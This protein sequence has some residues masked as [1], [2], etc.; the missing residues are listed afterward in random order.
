MKKYNDVI[1]NCA[2]WNLNKKYWKVKWKNL[3]KKILVNIKSR[4]LLEYIT[5]ISAQFTTVRDRWKKGDCIIN[6]AYSL[7]PSSENIP[8]YRSR[9]RRFI[10]F[11]AYPSTVMRHGIPTLRLFD[12][13]PVKWKSL[14]NN[15]Y[16]HLCPIFSHFDYLWYCLWFV[17]NHFHGLLKYR[18]RIKI[19]KNQE[20]EY[21]NLIV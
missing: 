15:D 18:N 7:V 21:N 1:Y 9:C 19:W 13:S 10:H 14:R 5:S 20:N 3:K 4:F 16:C 12:R 11:M 8:R 2:G 6:I 17:W